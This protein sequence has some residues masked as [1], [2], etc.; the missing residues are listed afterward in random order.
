MSKQEQPE[1][2]GFLK[3]LGLAAMAAPAVAVAEESHRADAVPAGAAQK[4]AGR[5]RT[6]ARYQADS[7]HVR[8]FYATNRY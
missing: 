2:R 6:K 7:A 4:E 3:T 8:A 5:E 1:R